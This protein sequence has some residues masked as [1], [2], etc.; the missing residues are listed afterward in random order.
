MK[1]EETTIQCPSCGSAIDVNDIL[2]HQIEDALRKEYQLKANEDKQ[3]LKLQSDNLAKDKA[4][5]EAKKQKENELF[6]ERMEK[7]LKLKEAEMKQKLTKKLE[8]ENQDQLMLL[9][10]ELD[11]KTEKVKELHKKDA[12]IAKLQRE[13]MEVKDAA[14]ASAQKQFTEQLNLERVKIKKQAEDEHEFK[15]AT[16]KKQLEDQKRLTEE[17]RRKQEQGSMQLQ[18][19]IM[20]LA[21]EEYLINTFPLDTI[22][23]IKKGANGADCVHVVNTR[24]NQNCGCIY[25]ESK[26][27]KVFQVAWI[28]KFKNDLRAKKADLGVL[29]TECLPGDMQRMGLKDGIWI[30]T[31]QE[32]KGLSAVLRESIIQLNKAMQTQENKGDKMVML[33]DYLTGN[34]F[35]SQVE[36]I[37]EAFEQMQG[38]LNKEKIAMNRIWAQREKQLDKVI[39]NTAGMHGAIKGIAGNAVQTIMALELDCT[40]EL[41][42]EN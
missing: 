15:E 19:E 38:D 34:E 32:F 23:E 22:S 12:E 5:F 18:G 16:L 41:L 4:E 20:E 17:M 29:V 33:Y 39:Q 1:T 24:E 7:E 21:I 31:F 25:Y 37:V 11:E 6:A 30:C 40:T 2:K 28:E 8:E 14:E 35:R 13:K 27:A 26:R 42:L 10:K 36:C 9:N 3:A